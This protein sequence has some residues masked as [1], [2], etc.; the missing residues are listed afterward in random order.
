MASLTALQ[1]N[2][3]H[4]I[5]DGIHHEY[6]KKEI[7]TK[8]NL[9]ASANISRIRKSLEQKELIDISPQ[10]VTINDPV[11]QLWLKRSDFKILKT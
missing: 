8:Y 7:L 4:A 1:M 6:S 5:V 2:F 3:L 10:K 9:G 11:F